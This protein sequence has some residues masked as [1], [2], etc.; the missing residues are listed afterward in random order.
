MPPSDEFVQRLEPLR[1]AIRIHCYRMLGSAHDGDDVVQETMLR[2]WRAKDSLADES[3]LKPWLY[4]IAT[5][6]CFDELKRRPKRLYPTDAFPPTNE[7]QIPVPKIEEAVW[8]EP[9]PSSWLEGVDETH[10]EARY[11]AKESV[12]LAFVAA[13]QCLSPIQRAVLL[14]RDVIGFSAAETAAA[15]ETSV[16]AVSSALFRARNAVP[17]DV[18]AENEV[19]MRVLEQYVGAFEAANLDALI[20]LFHQDMR[21]T[22]PPAPTWVSGRDAN[23]RF[24]RRMFGAIQPGQFRH[25]PIGINGRPGLAFYRP[26][27]PGGPKE[28]AAIQL[29]ATR[30]GAVYAVDHF[31]L[32][33]VYSLFHVPPHW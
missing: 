17:A 2:A 5:N 22:M 24:Y 32:P 31:M 30:N 7:P 21:T 28:L 26:A 12:A 20:A 16:E 4:R 8:L 13:L 10:P 23:E 9:M 6:V 11:D 3:L 18:A 29:V 1:G 14:L 25:R 33:E 15:L 19:D 27:T